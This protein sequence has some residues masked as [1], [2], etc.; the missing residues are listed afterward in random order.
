VLVVAGT[1]SVEEREEIER[2]VKSPLRGNW[3][4]LRFEKC[5]DDVTLAVTEG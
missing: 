3:P 5:L 2:I 1:R 4:E